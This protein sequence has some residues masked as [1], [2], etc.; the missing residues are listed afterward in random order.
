LSIEKYITASCVISNN[1]VVK[2]GGT[3]FTTA[4]TNLHNFLVAVYNHFGIAY[5]KFYK[6]DS[7]SKLGWLASEVLLKDSFISSDYAPA[8]TGIVLSNANASL[9]TD[10]KYIDTV[11]DI[12]SP[13]VFVYTLPNIVMGEICIRNNFKGENAFFVFEEFDAEFIHQYVSSLI[14]NDIVKAC[15]C[16]WADLLNEDYKAVLYLVEKDNAR[17][18]TL[19]TTENIT[20]IFNA[21]RE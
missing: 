3:I 14:D 16:G 4:A 11:K 1:A 20:N 18:S 19:F 15:I 9:D 17:P 2:N 7:L 6:M 5:P 10:L 21:G 8:D 13:S 12:A